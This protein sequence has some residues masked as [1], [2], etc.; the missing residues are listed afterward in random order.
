[1]ARLTGLIVRV[2]R[3]AHVCRLCRGPILAGEP[4]EELVG[5]PWDP[6]GAEG[7]RLGEYAVRRH[8]WRCVVTETEGDPALLSECEPY[9]LRFGSV[10][11]IAFRPLTKAG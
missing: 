6:F 8:C 1:M 5:R 10:R 11:F 2:A 3:T 7:E 9:V 4:Y